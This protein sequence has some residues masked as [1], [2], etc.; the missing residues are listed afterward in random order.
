M[1]HPS[2]GK[3]V[4]D[5]VEFGRPLADGQQQDPRLI[6]QRNDGAA[7]LELFVKILAAITD[8]LYPLIRLFVH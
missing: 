8:R 1:P 6:G 4:V 7:L 2:Q 3:T 5:F